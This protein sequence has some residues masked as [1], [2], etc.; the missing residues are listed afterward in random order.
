M[1]G[2]EH[3]LAAVFKLFFNVSMILVF[4]WWGLKAFQRYLSQPMVTDITTT[5]GDNGVSIQF[6]QI[7]ICNYGFLGQNDYMKDCVDPKWTYLGSLIN[8]LDSN[9]DFDIE[10][11][12]E[13]LDFNVSKF[14]HN[15]TIRFIDDASTIVL[16]NYSTKIWKPVFHDRFGLCYTLDISNAPG[17]EYISVHEKPYLRIYFS[18]ESPWKWVVTMIHSK[19]DLPDAMIMQP[20]IYFRLNGVNHN[21]N[22][23]LNVF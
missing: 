19:N 10:T 23:T 16:N 18:N 7:T 3:Y 17:Y 15:V 13:N 2:T 22:T 21:N 9:A 6:P 14:M 1:K 11:F 20:V 5:V 4:G 8:C 12:H